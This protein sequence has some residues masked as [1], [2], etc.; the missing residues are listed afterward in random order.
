MEV[1]RVEGGDA[2]VELETGE[3]HA[4]GVSRRDD[5]LG[6][7]VVGEPGGLEPDA[8]TTADDQERLTGE[9]LGALHHATLAPIAEASSATDSGLTSNLVGVAI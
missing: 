9:L 4:L 6:A 3:L 5:H 2:P 1:G 7:L 8:G